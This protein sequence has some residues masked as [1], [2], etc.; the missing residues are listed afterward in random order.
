[1][2]ESELRILLVNNAKKFWG[3]KEHDARHK[4]ILKIYN[5]IKPLPRGYRV[6]ENDAWCAAY[7]SAMYHLSML[8]KIAF[9]EC[10]VPNIVKA[11]R[12][13]GKWHAR[14]YTPKIGDLVVYDW[15]YDTVGDHIGIV[16]KVNAGYIDVM[17]GNYKD[18]CGMRTLKLTNT[19]ILGF[20][21]PNFA[22]LASPDKKCKCNCTC[23][24][25][26]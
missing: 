17:E 5:D 23:K 16:A 3:A 8:D 26:K 1:M 12:N 20:V 2:T 7:T 19:Q 15:N 11:A 24:C 6:T 13:A 4:Q 22:A 25:C 14:G 21:T 10:S 9:F 18:A